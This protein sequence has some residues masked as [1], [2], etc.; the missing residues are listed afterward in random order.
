MK[1][2]NLKEASKRTKNET[3][4]IYLN[5]DYNKNL[6]KNQNIS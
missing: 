5:Q 2:P 1:L 6:F 4:Y 3:E